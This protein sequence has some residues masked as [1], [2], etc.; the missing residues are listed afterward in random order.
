MGEPPISSSVGAVPNLN[1]D[2]NQRG[3]KN[4]NNSSHTSLMP[5]DNYQRLKDL[6]Q[7]NQR[8]EE[9]VQMMKDAVPDKD[10]S[11]HYKKIQELFNKI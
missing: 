3:K 7:A 2:D 1:D 4:L 6:E 11:E 8:L 9:Q 5:Q 10:I